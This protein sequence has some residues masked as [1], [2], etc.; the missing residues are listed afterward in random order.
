MKRIQKSI[1]LK[2]LVGKDLTENDRD[3]LILALKRVACLAKDFRR[4][5]SSSH[6][7]G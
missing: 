1:W 5:S 3:K 7:G 6:I 4:C 2:I